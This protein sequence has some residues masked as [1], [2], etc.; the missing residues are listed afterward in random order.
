[1]INQDGREVPDSVI[2]MLEDMFNDLD[3]TMVLN[4]DGSLEFSTII[5]EDR[6]VKEGNWELNG[7]TL[8]TRTDRAIEKNIIQDFQKDSMMVQRIGEA[9]SIKWIRIK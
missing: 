1:M 3:N 9:Q 5:G 4:K 6:V 7:D 8:I 2:T